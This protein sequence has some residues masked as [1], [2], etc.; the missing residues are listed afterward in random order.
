MGVRVER[1]M[2][3]TTPVVYLSGRGFNIVVRGDDWEKIIPY[4]RDGV[5]NPEIVPVER[6]QYLLPE[7][8]LDV[9]ILDR[10]DQDFYQR[11]LGVLQ[12][13]FPEDYPTSDL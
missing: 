7:V 11:V 4:L 9:A 12:G 2:F 10:T 8:M 5:F 3:Q 1:K 13:L 6:P